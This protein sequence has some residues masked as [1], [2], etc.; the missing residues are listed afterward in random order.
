MQGF[1]WYFKKISSRSTRPSWVF[2]F[3]LDLVNVAFVSVETSEM[4]V[5][6][7]QDFGWE[8]IAADF[9]LS[10]CP[11]LVKEAQMIVQFIMGALVIVVTANLM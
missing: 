4:H 7:A 9:Y 5:C 2:S 8:S 1:L 6:D 10:I 11:C 3:A